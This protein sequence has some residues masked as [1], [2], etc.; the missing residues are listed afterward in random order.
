MIDMIV[1]ERSHRE[2]A[3]IISVLKPQMHLPLPLGRLD[4]V[5]R[6]QLPLLVEIVGGALYDRQAHKGD[7]SDGEV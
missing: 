1:R 7:L 3:M 6:Q 5:L 2:I 4:K